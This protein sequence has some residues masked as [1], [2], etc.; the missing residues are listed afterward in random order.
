MMTVSVIETKRQQRLDELAEV[1]DKNK[2]TQ[3]LTI[4]GETLKQEPESN[5]YGTTKIFDSTQLTDKQ[6]FDYAQELAGSKKLTE[7]NPGIY[8][9]K[10]KD[11]TIITLRNRSSSNKNVRWTIDID[12]SKRLAKVA[13]KYGFHVEIKLK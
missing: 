5:R 3:T 1:F 9:A 8:K 4:E 2:P 10:L 11:S 13:N 7:V 12:H 6:I